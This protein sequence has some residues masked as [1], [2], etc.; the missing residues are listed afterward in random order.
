MDQRSITHFRV[1][2][3]RGELGVV[4]DSTKFIGGG[5]HVFGEFNTDL[6]E[7]VD[8]TALGWVPLAADREGL[9]VAA[10]CTLAD[11]A[12]LGDPGWRAH[13]LFFQA[14]SALLGSFKVWNV[15]TV[16]GNICASLP[17]G[18]MTSLAV[19]LDA[20][21]LVWRADGSD[22]IL[23]ARSFVTGIQENALRQ[24]DVLRSI[25]FPASSLAAHT[26]FRKIALSPLGRSGAVLIGRSES[27]GRFV[28]TVSA[29]TLRPEQVVFGETPTASQLRTAIDAI[30]SWFTDAHGAADWRHAVSAVLAEEIRLELLE[31]LEREDPAL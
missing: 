8:L 15:A 12:N 27:S 9:T 4:D 16:G 26:A 28:L 10:T 30:D 6:R 20:D 2:R 3:D 5:S 14:C 31:S 24:G 29:A 19:G 7:L 11:L 13:P 22:E 23:A 25:H 21:L 18:P 17:A 1:P